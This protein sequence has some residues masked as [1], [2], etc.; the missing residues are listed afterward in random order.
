MFRPKA[1]S[2]F[3]DAM[4]AHLKN[5]SPRRSRD[6]SDAGVREIIRFAIKRAEKHGFSRR[7][8]VRFYIELMFMF[9]GYFDTDPQHLWAARTLNEA[10]S[11][12]EMIRADRLFKAMQTYLDAASGPAHKFHI[13]ATQAL[14]K[15]QLADFAAGGV[16]LQRSISAKLAQIHPQKCRTIEPSQMDALLRT[17]FGVARDQHLDGDRGAI[18][19]VLLAFTLGHAFPSDPLHRWIAAPLAGKPLL[20]GDARIDALHS[21]WK[22]YL[23]G[24]LEDAPQ[25]QAQENAAFG[26]TNV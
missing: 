10:K 17:A 24:L 23:T 25:T 13:A 19:A 2:E 22:S 12:D 11:S 1:V 26:S 21:K 5:F 6:M 14:T 3:E 4:L 16:S 15:A 9:G 18:L 20:D 7:G 8:P